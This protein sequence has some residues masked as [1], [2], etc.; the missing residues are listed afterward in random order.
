MNSIFLVIFIGF[1]F[2][3]AIAFLLWITTR[4]G[5]LEK[6]L[7]IVKKEIEQSRRDIN[8]VKKQ[9]DIPPVTNWNDADNIVRKEGN[10]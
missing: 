7:E 2:I 6:E 8:N 4:K 1:S 9:R 10:K 3:V 5:K